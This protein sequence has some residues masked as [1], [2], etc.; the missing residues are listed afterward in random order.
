MNDRKRKFD[1]GFLARAQ[2]RS[3]DTPQAQAGLLD[4]PMPPGSAELLRLFKIAP[5][6]PLLVSEMA[7]LL[8]RALESCVDPVIALVKAGCLDLLQRADGGNHLVALTA[9]GRA[10]VEVM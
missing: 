6:K 10:Q 4:E 2:F 9:V 1:I 5:R 8:G 7:T 3:T